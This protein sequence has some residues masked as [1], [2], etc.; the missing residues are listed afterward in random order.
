MQESQGKG[1]LLQVSVN[2]SEK[3][4]ELE[5]KPVLNATFDEIKSIKIL[6]NKYG[7]HFYTDQLIF[8]V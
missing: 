8:T 4:T 5:G 2:I 6:L 1:Y 3:F 7:F